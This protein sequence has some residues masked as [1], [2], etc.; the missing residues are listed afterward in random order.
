MILKQV[1]VNDVVHKLLCSFCDSFCHHTWPKVSD[2]LMSDVTFCSVQ[3]FLLHFL[4]VFRGL[5][6]HNE[7]NGTGYDKQASSEEEACTRKCD[8]LDS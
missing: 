5:L 2:S 1:V 3:T 4:D 8:L 7:L 6:Y